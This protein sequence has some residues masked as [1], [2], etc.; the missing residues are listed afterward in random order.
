MLQWLL[1]QQ[2]SQ[3]KLAW[4]E[5]AGVCGYVEPTCYATKELIA[6]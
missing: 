3:S 2:L 4:T 1:E 6:S 5:L